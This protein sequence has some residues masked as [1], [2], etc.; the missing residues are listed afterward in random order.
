[1]EDAN[2]FQMSVGERAKLKCSADYAYGERGHPGVYP[3]ILIC[4]VV[5]I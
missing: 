1:M 3:F 4:W 2:C 5:V